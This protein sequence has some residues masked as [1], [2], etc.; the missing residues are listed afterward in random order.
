MIRAEITVRRYDGSSCLVCQ[1]EGW[2]SASFIHCWWKYERDLRHLALAQKKGKAKQKKALNDKW[3]VIL[4]HFWPCCSLTCSTTATNIFHGEPSADWLATEGS[5][6]SRTTC[7]DG[8]KTSS[9]SSSLLLIL[10]TSWLS[11][12]SWTDSP[13]AFFAAVFIG[14]HAHEHCLSAWVDYRS[15]LN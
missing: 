13:K 10:K 7:A 6:T 3:H 12:V 4:S 5:V 2:H 9:P 1:D 14:M 15:I 11:S 8:R